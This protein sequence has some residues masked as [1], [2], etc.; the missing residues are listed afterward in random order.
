M[1]D[2]Y[3]LMAVV[4]LFVLLL[5]VSI[6]RSLILLRLRKEE[7]RKQEL[8]LDILEKRT[9]VIERGRQVAT[10]LE[11]LIYRAHVQQ[12]IEKLIRKKGPS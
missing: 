5:G 1:I 7:N 2:A 12:E 10:N 9:A 3:V 6:G 8:E 11:E 4:N